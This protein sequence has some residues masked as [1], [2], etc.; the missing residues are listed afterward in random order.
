MAMN[1]IFNID[2]PYPFEGGPWWWRAAEMAILLGVAFVLGYFIG[3]KRK[4]SKGP[5]TPIRTSGWD[6]S[7]ALANEARDLSVK[8][9]PGDQEVPKSP[10]MES[11]EPA[12]IHSPLLSSHDDLT[13]IEGIG[14]KLAQILQRSNITSFKQLS[15]T[16]SLTL[17]G[18]LDSEGPQFKVHDPTYWPR[19]AALAHAGKWEELR[20]L[21]SGLPK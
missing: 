19:Q 14:P 20:E 18:I 6:T 9:D 7:D 21:Q 8:P 2:L 17:R 12:A 11:R 15:E 16:S 10:K 1:E 13:L 4:Q 3:C 5:D